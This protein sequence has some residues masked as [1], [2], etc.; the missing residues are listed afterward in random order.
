MSIFLSVVAIIVIGGIIW[1][2]MEP[3]NYEV[4]RRRV[5]KVSPEAVYGNVVELKQ[6][7]KWN[8]WIMHEP[9]ATL[10]YGEPTN[11]ATG[12]YSWEGQFIGSGKMTQTSMIEN[13]AI[14]QALEFYTTAVRDSMQADEYSCDTKYSCATVKFEDDSSE[15][16]PDHISPPLRYA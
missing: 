2:S 6:W 9:D 7:S 1:L 11:A 12:W 13:Q 5:I 14:E 15:S 10:E 16:V 3:A 4:V 8:P